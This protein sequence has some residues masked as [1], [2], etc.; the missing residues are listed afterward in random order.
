MEAPFQIENRPIITPLYGFHSR[1][2][3]RTVVGAA[4]SPLDFNRRQ[5]LPDAPSCHLA[6]C[7]QKDRP[8]RWQSE[9]RSSVPVRG[10]ELHE[11]KTSGFSRR[12]VTT[13][14][15]TD[16]STGLHRHQD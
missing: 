2:E 7:W 15:R 6:E 12:T 4:P 11:L 13:I 16:A 5:K 14:T 1:W 10:Q 8:T 9:W 3:T